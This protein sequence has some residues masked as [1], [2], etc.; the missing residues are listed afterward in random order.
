MKISLSLS[1]FYFLQ[2]I[3]TESLP[4]LKLLIPYFFLDFQ[5]LK[6][7]ENYKECE[8]NKYYE[9]FE[10]VLSAV[11]YNETTLLHAKNDWEKGDSYRVFYNVLHD[12]LQY[13][14]LEQR[15]NYIQGLRIGAC[16]ATLAH[17]IGN[18]FEKTL[19]RHNVSSRTNYY[20][21]PQSFDPEN[22]VDGLCKYCQYLPYRLCG[23]D[24]AEIIIPGVVV[25]AGSWCDYL[26]GKLISHKDIDIW[27]KVPIFQSG[28]RTFNGKTYRED[29]IDFD[30]CYDFE[31]EP[32]LK[33][34]RFG[35]LN[36]ILLPT[37]RR[38]LLLDR[39]DKPYNGDEIDFYI[40]PWK[41]AEN[42]PLNYLDEYEDDFPSMKITG[43]EVVSRFNHAVTRYYIA[44]DSKDKVWV[45]TEGN[46]QGKR[47][48]F[49]IN[50]DI[51][52]ELPNWLK[53]Y[54]QKCYFKQ[55]YE[56]PTKE[57]CLKCNGF[58]EMEQVDSK[59]GKCLDCLTEFKSKRY[60]YK[61][62]NNVKGECSTNTLSAIAERKIVNLYNK[63]R[64][65]E[66]NALKDDVILSVQP[67]LFE[68]D[69]AFSS[70]PFKY[71]D[72]IRSL[73]GLRLI[74]TRLIHYTD[75]IR[76]KKEC[77]R[78][79]RQ[80]YPDQCFFEEVT[81][82]K[83]LL[84]QKGHMDDEEFIL[85]A[86]I[87]LK[88]HFRTLWGRPPLEKE[89]S[90]KVK[91]QNHQIDK[92]IVEL[93]L[94]F[95]CVIFFPMIE[96]YYLR[97]IRKEEKSEETR[98]AYVYSRTMRRRLQLAYSGMPIQNFCLYYLC[99]HASNDLSRQV[100]GLE[101]DDYRRY[102]SRVN[103]TTRMLTRQSSNDAFNELFQ[104]IDVEN[105]DFD[106]STTN[107]NALKGKAHVYDSLCWSFFKSTKLYSKDLVVENSPDSDESY[108]EA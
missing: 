98:R 107:Y 87:I 48:N 53:R 92:C 23:L 85:N 84:Y 41:C 103:L 100:F 51:G 4:L 21:V 83:A 37:H 56:E 46:V 66:K 26:A 7:I 70:R 30:H 94:W 69:N 105:I 99:S 64:Y 50:T 35:M 106:A 24:L 65:V 68:D 5:V 97:V 25:I 18:D 91:V 71:R 81:A 43:E 55:G 93:K 42:Y 31:R 28:Y 12:S 39:A 78:V 29:V 38:K 2:K 79:M 96:N 95:C 82:L 33:S 52:R 60:P 45:L 11:G 6:D 44:Y 22:F 8:R 62:E 47:T 9:T 27:S 40:P 63:P 101:F 20:K 13:E 32:R 16:Y 77:I 108:D 88:P 67:Y 102:F 86:F 90:F 19:D 15:D 75:F 89:K 54:T 104:R 49:E 59:Q 61:H 3:Y 73:P 57:K 34:Y 80:L 10:E 72:E 36:G 76:D 14:T 58:F 1:V 74:L 17:S